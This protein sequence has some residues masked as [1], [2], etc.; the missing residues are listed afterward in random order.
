VIE[1]ASNA[2]E[3]LLLNAPSTVTFRSV[4]GASLYSISGR[5]GGTNK[6]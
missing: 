6:R 3:R 1:E 5:S 2:F 4:L